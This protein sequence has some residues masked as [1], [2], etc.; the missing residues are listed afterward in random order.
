MTSTELKIKRES[1]LKLSFSQ[2]PME[3][4]LCL[5]ASL[6]NL[7]KILSR[8]IRELGMYL[9]RQHAAKIGG[10]CLPRKGHQIYW[11]MVG[12]AMS[13][14]PYS[15]QELQGLLLAQKPLNYLE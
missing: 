8:S 9:R 14:Y 6:C 13:L 2:H 10:V 7:A 1:S 11:N 5:Y 15:Q 3:T 12:G 4:M